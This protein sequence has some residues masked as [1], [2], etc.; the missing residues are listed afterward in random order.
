M[1]NLRLLLKSLIKEVLGDYSMAGSL[2]NDAPRNIRTGQSVIQTR[3]N[4]ISDEASNLSSMRKVARV[5]IRRDDGKILTIVSLKDPSHISLPGGGV[6]PG[7]SLED[8]ARRELWEETGL[9]AGDLILIRTDIGPTEET[10]I[11][12]AKNISGKIRSSEEGDVSWRDSKDLLK[13]GLL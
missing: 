9:I 12:R 5:L 3:G 10:T 2:R 1:Q 7:E 8:A 11:F 13:I 6:E 4:V